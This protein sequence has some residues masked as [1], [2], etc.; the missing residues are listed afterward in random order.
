MTI[1]QLPSFAFRT[2]GRLRQRDGRDPRPLRPGARCRRRRPPRARPGLPGLQ[3]VVVQRGAGPADDLDRR[4]ARSTGRPGCGASRAT[5]GSSSRSRSSTRACPTG[6]AMDGLTAD[7][8]RGR[9]PARTGSG[10]RTATEADGTTYLYGDRHRWSKLATLLTHTGLVLFLVAAAVTSRLGFEAGI[11]ARPAARAS[12]S[13]SIGTPGLHRRQ[14]LRVRGAAPR[15]R[16]L[17]RLHDRP[18]RLPRRPGARAQGRPG[19]RPAV[20]RRLHVPPE[21]LPAGA[22]T[23]SSATRRGRVLWDGPVA[24]TDAVAGP[25]ARPVQRPGP[26]RRASRCS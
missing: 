2:A 11:L 18:G 23:W 14:E 1:R 8:R 21:R 19:Q 7:G 4:A 16:Q 6:R 20:G 15:G 5:S 24:L 26:R 13:S 25:A 10:V 12:R 3:L 17:R 9:P 22:R